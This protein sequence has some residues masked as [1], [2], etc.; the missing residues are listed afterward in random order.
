MPADEIEARIVKYVGLPIEKFTEML[1]PKSWSVM[2]FINAED[3]IGA[4]IKKDAETI[5]RI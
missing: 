3:R 1:R 5:K 4:V 2:G